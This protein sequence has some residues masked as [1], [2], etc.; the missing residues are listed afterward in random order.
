M[1][2]AMKYIGLMN[3]LITSR[4]ASGITYKAKFPTCERNGVDQGM[5]NVLS[6]FC[7]IGKR[8]FERALAAFDHKEPVQIEWKAF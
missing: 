8:K 6:P 3:S 1:A 7:Y 2:G 5:H 4:D